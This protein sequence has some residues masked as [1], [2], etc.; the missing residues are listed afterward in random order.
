[1]AT[2]LLSDA[3][4]RQRLGYCKSSHC[5]SGPSEL[6]LLGV[7][8]LWVKLLQVK[9]LWVN[10]LRVFLLQVNYCWLS[11]QKYNVN[12]KQD[13]FGQKKNNKLI[14][15]K[16]P[17]PVGIEEEN[18][19]RKDLVVVQSFKINLCNQW[20][21]KLLSLQSTIVARVIPRRPHPTASS[22]AKSP[23]YCF[24]LI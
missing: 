6:K 16:P 24:S 15:K 5:G 10:P 1:M 22:Q 8:P 21:V 18:Q 12:K 14:G 19:D 20:Y 11:H 17:N 3:A 13:H 4:S 9:L 7:K 23:C 2:V